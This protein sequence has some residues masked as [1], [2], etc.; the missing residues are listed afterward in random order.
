MIEK[1]LKN[2]GGRFVEGLTTY[3]QNSFV[4][5]YKIFDRFTGES[6]TIKIDSFNADIVVVLK[7]ILDEKIIEHRDKKINS[8]INGD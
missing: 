2:Y 1:L 3:D 6:F 4:P 7:N 5:T 8:V